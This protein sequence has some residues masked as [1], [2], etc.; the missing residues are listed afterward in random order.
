M[1][2]HLHLP[3][4]A[5]AGLESLIRHCWVGDDARLGDEGDLPREPMTALESP[6]SAEGAAERS[7]E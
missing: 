6:W 7:G 1:R 3:L 4:L 5:I 2:K